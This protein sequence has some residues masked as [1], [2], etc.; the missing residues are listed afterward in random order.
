MNAYFI[1][2]SI[3][4][5]IDAGFYSDVS[6][7]AVKSAVEKEGWLVTAIKR[8]I[9]LISINGSRETMLGKFEFSM[10]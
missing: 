8:K 10:D 4:T 2:D 6:L 5:P 3:P 1:P 9:E 7:N